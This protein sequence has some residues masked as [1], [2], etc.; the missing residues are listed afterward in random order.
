[1]TRK[2][3]EAIWKKTLPGGGSIPDGAPTFRDGMW[4]VPFK[5]NNF[6]WQAFFA[7]RPIHTDEEEVQAVIDLRNTIRKVLL[8]SD[9]DPYL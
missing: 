3:M 1:M 4:T 2:Q 5:H 8:M 6:A 7:D 9:E